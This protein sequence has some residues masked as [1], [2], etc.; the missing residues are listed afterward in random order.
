MRTRGRVDQNQAALVRV[1]RQLG[2]SWVSLANLGAGVPDALVGFRGRTVLVEVKTPT[3]KLTPDQ[4]QFL[5]TWRGEPVVIVRTI[6]DLV[7]MLVPSAQER[8]RAL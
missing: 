6:D 2:A 5:T 3:G 1:A 4:E 8:G 7:K